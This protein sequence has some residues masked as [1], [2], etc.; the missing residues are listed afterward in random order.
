LTGLARAVTLALTLPVLAVVTGVAPIVLGVRLLPLGA[1]STAYA[2]ISPAPSCFTR[3]KVA[4]QACRVSI[5]LLA[6]AC[7]CIYTVDTRAAVQTRRRRAVVRVAIAIIAKVASC[8]F[9]LVHAETNFTVCGRFSTFA[10]LAWFRGALVDIVLTINS[11]VSDDARACVR[12]PGRGAAVW[13]SVR[14]L[15]VSAR[16]G[17]AD[18]LRR[19]ASRTCPAIHTRAD[20]RVGWRVAGRASWCG[21]RATV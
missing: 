21:A 16:A 20:G 10:M 14:D 18:V 13:L 15:S 19:L 7:E 1:Q 3:R 5:A 17:S 2:W 8:A 4:V 6:L 9:T 11:I 12:L